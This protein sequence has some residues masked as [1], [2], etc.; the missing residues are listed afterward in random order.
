M[1]QFPGVDV[2]SNQTLNHALRGAGII[3]LGMAVPERVLTNDDLAKLVETSDEWIVSRTGIKQR[4]VCDPDTTTSDL[5]ARAALAA[6]ADANIAP[7]DLD[8]VLCATATGDYLWPST[9]C[10]IQHKI[11]ATNAAAFDLSAACSGFCYGLTVAGGLLRTGE[12]QNI[13]VIGADTL[14]KQLDWHDRGTCIL[15]GDG[16]GAAVLT[17]CSPEEGIMAS[18]LGADGSGVESIWMP[19]GGVRTPLTSDNIGAGLNCIHMKGSEVYKFA[20]R[21][22]P[23]VIERVLVRAKLQPED[24]GLLVMHQANL[25]IIQAVAERFGIDDERVFVNLHK[26]GNTSAASIPI[27]LTEAQAEGR[28]Q[29]GKV[30]VTV[31]FGAGLTWGANVLRWNK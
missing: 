26:Y 24:I 4:H 23:E 2:H 22:V 27:A 8:L 29:R 10:V 20:V 18:Y 12:M 30:V 9:A 19:G 31:G 15:F 6:L 13:L 16:A 25:R 7:G 21:I 5:A 11:G 14:T 1:T 28:L 3:G 17:A